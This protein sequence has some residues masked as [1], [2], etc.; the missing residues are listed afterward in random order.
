MTTTASGAPER[1]FFSRAVFVNS[2]GVVI[3]AILVSGLAHAYGETGFALFMSGVATVLVMLRVLPMWPL[4]RP[5]ERAA[6]LEL[7]A[8][9]VRGYR[10][11][12]IAWRHVQRADILV[13]GADS[14]RARLV[15]TLWPALGGHRVPLD[16]HRLEGITPAQVL[17][18]VERRLAAV[19]AA[20]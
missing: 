7:D 13:S 2:V 17:V 12:T 20:D 9:G 3:L 6:W 5:G 1:L 14:R 16:V 15:L 10:G 19:R 18:L 4:V 8:D 11:R